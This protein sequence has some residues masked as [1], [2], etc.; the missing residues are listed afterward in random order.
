[1]P[2]PFDLLPIEGG[3]IKVGVRL[4]KAQ[5]VIDAALIDEV[6]DDLRWRGVMSRPNVAADGDGEL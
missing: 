6:K 1:M 5:D 3:R 4:Q 2:L